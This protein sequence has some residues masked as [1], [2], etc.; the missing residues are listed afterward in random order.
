MEPNTLLDAIRNAGPTA[1]LVFI[2]LYFI[3]VISLT[4]LQKLPPP[5]RA[6]SA[7]IICLILILF[8]ILITEALWG[9]V[10]PPQCPALSAQCLHHHL[11]P[12][13]FLLQPYAVSPAMFAQGC[14]RSRTNVLAA[15]R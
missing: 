12:D 15:V 1:G 5:P 7:R 9:P 4:I 13:A 11:P 10:A 2:G 3:W 14:A 8:A 6:A